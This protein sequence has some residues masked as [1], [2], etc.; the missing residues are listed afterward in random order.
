MILPTLALGI[1]IYNRKRNG[2]IKLLFLFVI[3]GL[4]IVF[5][6]SITGITAIVM[7]FGLA[8][9]LK[10]E[11]KMLLRLFN[12]IVVIVII[13]C[14]NLAFVVFSLQESLLSPLQTLFSS[15]EFA[16]FSHRTYVWQAGL[17]LIQSKPILGIGSTSF[18][19]FLGFSVSHPHNYIMYV[20]LSGGI[21]GLLLS[22]MFFYQT[23]SSMYKEKKLFES[24]LYIALLIVILSMG[25]VESLTEFPLLYAIL[26]VGYK[27]R[28][29]NT[30][31][32]T[33][34]D[35]RYVP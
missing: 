2:S 7:F 15:K 21:I 9:M 35:G 30:E 11:K 26:I 14:I 31:L 34:L 4:S 8:F 20:L 29:T 28:K 1:T 19:S 23:V 6:E 16:T 5:V 25:I 24:R 3:A 10:S 27:I 18:N 13:V 17:L 32:F 33:R 22:L 12:P